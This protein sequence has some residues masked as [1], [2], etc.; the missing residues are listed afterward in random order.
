MNEKNKKNNYGFAYIA[1]GTGNP[2][3]EY[4]D[5]EEE[6]KNVPWWRLNDYEE[7][8]I[9]KMDESDIAFV[10]LRHKKVAIEVSE[11]KDVIVSKDEFKK[12]LK[13]YYDYKDEKEK[14]KP[15]VRLIKS[16]TAYRDCEENEKEYKFYH[17]IDAVQEYVGKENYHTFTAMYNT[18][19][20]FLD[21]ETEEEKI[22]VIKALSSYANAPEI[23]VEI[24]E[25]LCQD[26]TFHTDR[27]TYYYYALGSGELVVYDP[28]G[29]E[30]YDEVTEICK[31]L[32][33]QHPKRALDALGKMG[34]YF[35]DNVNNTVN[36]K[37]YLLYFSNDRVENWEI[38]KITGEG[39][40]AKYSDH[41]VEFLKCM[42]EA[43]EEAIYE[44]YT[45]FYQGSRDY[46]VTYVETYE[47]EEE[48]EDVEGE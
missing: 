39:G 44:K 15:I 20:F 46:V 37:D 11:G 31:L 24:V 47:E 36:S 26:G 16:W 5:K 4:R 3:W 48:K 29:I 40:S 14:G 38:L 27:K 6:R 8:I 41:E 7:I 28:D 43:G 2:E 32:G 13:K 9:E 33:W 12:L 1:S 30:Y 25:L 23:K 21:K 34:Y 17:F 45:S 42:N 35:G 19:T 22:E 10:G 18:I